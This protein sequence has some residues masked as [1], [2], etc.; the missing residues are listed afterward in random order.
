MYK[1]SCHCKQSSYQVSGD[2]KFEFMCYCDDC[3]VI[4]NGRLCGVGFD[5][6][7]LK[8]DGPLKVYAYAG[9]SGKNIEAHFCSNCSTTLFAYPLAHEDAVV[10]RANTLEDPSIFQPQQKLFE[11]KKGSWEN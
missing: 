8:H 1:G 7:A 10:I 2:K 9:G 3:K 6:S 5:K 4:A 11:E